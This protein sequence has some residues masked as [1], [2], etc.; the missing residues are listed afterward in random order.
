MF[1]PDFRDMTN[2]CRGMSHECDLDDGDDAT[3][4]M[5]DATAAYTCMPLSRFL[6]RLQKGISNSANITPR[7]LSTYS[8]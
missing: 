3:I 4:T 8:V 2:A 7:T 5:C 1:A 6:L